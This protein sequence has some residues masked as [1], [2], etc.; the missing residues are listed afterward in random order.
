LS[1]IVRRFAPPPHRFSSRLV[2][3]FSPSEF[4]SSARARAI[5]SA[6]ISR[7]IRLSSWRIFA[8]HIQLLQ[9]VVGDCG[10]VA[11]DTIRVEDFE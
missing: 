2:P 7:P 11:A 10:D 5:L 8:N 9:D 1:Q 4:A 3:G 6:T